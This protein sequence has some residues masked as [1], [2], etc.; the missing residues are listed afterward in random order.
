MEDKNRFSSLLRDAIH[1]KYLNG[2][3][4][5]QTSRLILLEDYSDDEYNQNFFATFNAIID[6]HRDGVSYDDIDKAYKGSFSEAADQFKRY[7]SI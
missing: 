5:V 7:F 3:K 1:N 2:E 4:I 6:D